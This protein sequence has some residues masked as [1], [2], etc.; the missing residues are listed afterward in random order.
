MR[1]AV[2]C[3]TAKNRT[4]LRR[5][6]SRSDLMPDSTPPNYEITS[7]PEADTKAQL[8]VTGL[9][10]AAEQRPLAS[11]QFRLVMISFLAAGIGLLAGVIAF[12]LYRLIG[13]FTNIAFYGHFSS[14]FV[15]PR[16]AIA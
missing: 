6:G 15:S 5:K 8:S 16:Y 11:A 10:T 12:L 13:L 2:C 14:A 1:C 4:S 7:S 3:R 9:N